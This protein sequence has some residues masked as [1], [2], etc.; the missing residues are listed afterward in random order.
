[1]ILKKDQLE[2]RLEKALKKMNKRMK[3][4]DYNER[5][6]CPIYNR[7]VARVDKYAFALQKMQ[8]EKLDEYYVNVYE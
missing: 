1:M 2:S 6:Q 4:N 8:I 7:F 3:L 5:I